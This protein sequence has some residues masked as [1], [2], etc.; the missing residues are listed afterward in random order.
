MTLVMKRPIL[1]IVV[2]FE[3]VTNGREWCS[4]LN[5]LSKLCQQIFNGESCKL[6]LLPI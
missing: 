2:T 3:T 6:I 4:G 5:C 1:C